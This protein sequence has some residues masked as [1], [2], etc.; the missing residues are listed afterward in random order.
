[1]LQIPYRTLKYYPSK[2]VAISTMPQRRPQQAKWSM[3]P[4]MHD[5]VA[6]LLEVEDLYFTFHDLDE[7]TGCIR[8]YDTCIM[9][10][11]R[12]R[13]QKC[14]SKGWS[15]KKIAVTIRMYPGERYNARVYHQSCKTC[16]LIS[17]PILDDS[18]AERVAYRLKKWNGVELE[19]PIFSGKSKGPHEDDLCEGCKAGHCNEGRQMDRLVN[20][21]SNFVLGGH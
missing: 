3:F 16:N 11:F 9:G 10:R 13:N 6:H 1:M 19:R 17:K 8:D 7:D 5:K 15:S 12:C 21:F 20:V 18:Y 4:L 2:I 14:H